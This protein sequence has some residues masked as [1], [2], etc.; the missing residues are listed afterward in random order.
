MRFWI[1]RKNDVPIREQIATQILLAI[2]SGELKPGERLPSIRSLARRLSVHANTI[3]AAYRDL[4]ARNWVEMR[5]GSGVYVRSFRKNQ[6]GEVELDRLV[7]TLIRSARDRGHSLSEIRTR[8]KYWLDVEPPDHFLVVEEDVELRRIL[9]YEIGNSTGFPVE[10]IGLDGCRKAGA[11]TGAALAA[12]QGRADA[13]REALPE[14]YECLWL[15]THTVQE[16]LQK[17]LRPLS[18][19]T[20]VVVAM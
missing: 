20:F 5:K 2:Y 9:E 12:L 17:Y 10:G 19:D 1:S 4:A 7:A 8:V 18:D 16:E 3:N 13:V 14:G 15:E 6:E 11:L